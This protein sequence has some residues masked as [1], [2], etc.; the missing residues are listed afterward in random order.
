MLSV[1]SLVI[2]VSNKSLP[3]LCV[4]SAVYIPSYISLCSSHC[5]FVT[6]SSG[7]HP[8]LKTPATP[9]ERHPCFLS[10][11]STPHKSEWN[12]P[13][14]HGVNKPDGSIRITV[15]YSGTINPNIIPT[16]HPTPRPHTFSN[17]HGVLDTCQRLN[18][19]KHTGTLCWTKNPDISLHFLLLLM[20]SCN[21]NGFA[22][23]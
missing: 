14:V 20:V 17:V 3:V 1:V 8:L 10:L 19:K 6:E 23:E 18:L 9:K 12:S 5:S 21:S 16:I 2:I 13:V 22:L 11:G 4:S 15:D 7:Y